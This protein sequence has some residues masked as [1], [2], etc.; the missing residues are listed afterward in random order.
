VAGHYDFVCRQGETFDRTV[1]WSDAAGV[2]VD[3]TGW[4]GRMQARGQAG[5]VMEFSTADGSMTLGGV[6]G[7]VRL[8]KTPAQTAAAP[9]GS[10]DYDL[11][12]TRTS[13]GYT[14]TILEGKFTVRPKVTA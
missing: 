14:K 6:A 11:P 2:P 10:Y 8:L 12:L 4:T 9:A 3:L 13:D 7:T 5:V 1:K